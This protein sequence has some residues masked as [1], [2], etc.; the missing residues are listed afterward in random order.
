MRVVFLGFATWGVTTLEGLLNAGHDVSLVITHPESTHEY[1][2]IWNESVSHFASAHGIP[3]K[4][5]LYANDDEIVQL[6]AETRPDLI[7]SSDWRTWLCPAILK[8]PKYGSINIHDAL[9]PKYG[10]FAPVNWAI[11]N[12]ECETGVT[13][14]FIQN[15]FDLGDIILQA[16]IP[17]EFSDTATDIFYKTLPFFSTLAVE[18][19][20]LIGNGHVLL[21]QQDRTMATFYHKRSERDSLIDWN[22]SNIHIYN[23][24]RAHSD[25]YP[26][27]HTYLNGKKL[28]VKKASLPDRSYCGTPGRVFCRTKNG[29][30]IVCG[31]NDQGYLQ[32]LVVELVQAEN[33]EPTEADKYF[34]KM[35]DYLG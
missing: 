26:N 35:G 28:K 23:L 14:H 25:P 1:E 21:T 16:K 3:T 17:I 32:G 5:C 22:K 30:V 20:N 34:K 6:I 33:E 29:V 10:G 24:V 19:L 4:V 2:I 11:I 18:A 15:E 12:G 9:L 27:A 7:V 13:V 31:S 8:L